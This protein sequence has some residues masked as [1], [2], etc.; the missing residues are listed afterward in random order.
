M[1]Y[2]L[3]LKPI[4]NK[5]DTFPF[6]R[7]FVTLDHVKSLLQ[8]LSQ[9]HKQIITHKEPTEYHIRTNLHGSHLKFKTYRT[10][11]GKFYTLS[12]QS[13]MYLSY[14]LLSDF[15]QEHVRICARR[16]DD[17]S[18]L[19]YWEK[20]VEKITKEIESKVEQRDFIRQN[21][22]ECTQFHPE[23]MTAMIKFFHAKKILDFCAGWGD[24]LA[25]CI[26][27]D[28][29]IQKYTGIDANWSLFKGYEQMIKEYLPKHSRHKYEMIQGDC[30]DILPKLNDMYDFIFT[31]PPYFDKEF[32][33][34]GKTDNDEQ[35]ILKY[36]ENWLKD[37]LI[38]AIGL[39]YSLLAKN[40][41]III[42]IS[43]FEQELVSQ[44]S[45][46]ME[47]RGVI[48]CADLSLLVWCRRM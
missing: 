28:D 5:M 14:G 8:K 38:N 43:G 48:K 37:F 42:A 10:D 44:V 21:V 4:L 20:N 41:H 25:A 35:S 16:N 7:D 19:E 33:T 45:Y 47:Y 29:V 12:L 11:P 6:R 40:G 31:C 36:T 39:A 17:I 15:F 23:I 30:I 24:R 18:P 46:L 26:S 9:T 2:K 22:K 27:M 13:N 34:D 3:K 32:Y 1:Y